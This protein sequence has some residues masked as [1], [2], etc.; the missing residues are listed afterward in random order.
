MK[1]WHL[2]V[3]LMKINI[4]EARRWKIIIEKVKI[5]KVN[6]FKFEFRTINITKWF[7]IRDRKRTELELTFWKCTRT[8]PN[9]NWLLENEA[10]PNRTR[11]TF[12]KMKSNRTEPELIFGAKVKQ[13]HIWNEKLWAKLLSTGTNFKTSVKIKWAFIDCIYLKTLQKT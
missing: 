9:P 1:R 4:Y 11:T 2:R 12:W 7:A 3:Y 6:I 8:E 5:G 10:E 13:N